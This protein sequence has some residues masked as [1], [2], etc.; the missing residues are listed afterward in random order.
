MGQPTV[1]AV[2]PARLASTRFPRKVLASETGI[3]LIVYACRVAER[4]CAD[5]VI[6]ATDAE[7]IAEAVREAGVEVVMTGEHSNG[8][9]RVTEA[10]STLDC[11]IVVNVQADEPELDPEV[12]NKSVAALI[13]AGA[14]CPMA[15][16][17][18]PLEA[19]E[20]EDPNVVK[21]TLDGCGEAANFS[22]EK[23]DGVD[24]LRHLG[25]YVYRA[26]FLPKYA[27]LAATSDEMGQ[28][29]EQLRV[30]GHGYRMAVACVGAQK[31]GIDTPEQYAAFVKR[32]AGA[33][34]D[35]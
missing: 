7:E 8:T 1:I 18:C 21:V 11:D 3:P 6:V 10:V 26:G 35:S 27:S 23:K 19:G 25:L 2:I 4:S 12:I 29:L 28:R 31:G 22:R 24:Q 30:I 15:T 17:A 9:S 14:E 20:S 5:R 32:Q 16:A 34:P 33:T 13:A